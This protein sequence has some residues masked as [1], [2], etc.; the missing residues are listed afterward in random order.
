MEEKSI[1]I[2]SD[3][4]LQLTDQRIIFE[5]DFGRSEILL[6][7][8]IGSK[9]VYENIGHY[10]RKA[11]FWAACC[12][13]C[14]S[15]FLLAL[16][17]LESAETFVRNLDIIVILLFLGACVSFFILIFA[18]I[19]FCFG[20]RAYLRIEGR[21]NDII[22]QLHPWRHQARKFIRRIKEQTT[23]LEELRKNAPESN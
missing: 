19:Y 12:L 4:R 23:R 8:Y 22:V 5:K 1:I 9:I 7:D 3:Q 13:L 2:S 17:G 14:L 18:V 11:I 6:K 20:R 21:F 16:A 10:D 15:P